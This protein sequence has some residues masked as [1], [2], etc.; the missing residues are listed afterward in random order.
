[1][2]SKDSKDD[3]E[4]D[5]VDGI[6]A[7]TKLNKATILKKATEYIVY[8]KKANQKIKGENE[9]LKKL[10]EELPGGIELY[11]AHHLETD[12]DDDLTLGSS[13]T[14]HSGNSSPYHRDD[15]DYIPPNNTGSRAFM[16]LFMCMTFFSTPTI[17]T[18]SGHHVPHH[19]H[20]SSRVVSNEIPV[21]VPPSSYSSNSTTFTIDIW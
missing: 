15:Y 1:M 9:K 8:L 3:E 10:F 7:A 6:P 5:K 17:T 21:D 4:D 11:R 2:K 16:A 14:D 19:H 13:G 18:N 12:D 20:D